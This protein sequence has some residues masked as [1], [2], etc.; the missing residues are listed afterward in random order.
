MPAVPRLCSQGEGPKFIPLLPTK[1]NYKT[2][3]PARPSVATNSS[4]S[5]LTPQPTTARPAPDRPPSALSPTLGRFPQ[6]PLPAPAVAL[7]SAPAPLAPRAASQRGR[8][9]RRSA[10]TRNGYGSGRPSP[11]GR[12]PPPDGTARGEQ[13]E[14]KEREGKAAEAAG[15]ASPR[16]PPRVLTTRSSWRWRRSGTGCC[17]GSARRGSRRR[18]RAGVCGES[19]AGRGHGTAPP[20]RSS[21][22]CSSLCRGAPGSSAPSCGAPRPPA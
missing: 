1:R 18:R 21:R 4:G 20:A 6:V 8:A 11:S 22:L 16:A 3:G 19:A 9:A 7:P 13:G 15:S 14:G 2:Y 10:A 12:R 5:L 17:L